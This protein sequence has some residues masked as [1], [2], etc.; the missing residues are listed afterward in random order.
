MV[1]DATIRPSGRVELQPGAGLKHF[2]LVGQPD[3]GMYG[4]VCSS[5]C[6]LVLGEVAGHDGLA[7]SARRSRVGPL[8]YSSQA[9]RV[10]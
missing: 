8:V 7:V 5:L 2:T 1:F 9:R 4:I 10:C 3:R 6:G